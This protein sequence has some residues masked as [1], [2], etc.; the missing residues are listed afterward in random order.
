MEQLLLL[1]IPASVP[2]PV[3][4]KK[5]AERFTTEEWEKLCKNQRFL[6]ELMIENLS[7]TR[8]AAEMILA[9]KPYES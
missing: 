7:K 6:D 8:I 2:T 1:D 5:F 4:V 3:S 9:G